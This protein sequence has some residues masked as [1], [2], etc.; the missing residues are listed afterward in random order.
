MASSLERICDLSARKRIEA[1][2]IA[3]K[4]EKHARACIEGD[5]SPGTLGPLAEFA[6]LAAGLLRDLA[7]INEGLAEAAKGY[8]GRLR[9]L[10]EAAERAGA[11][12]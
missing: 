8:G 7:D 4:L 1:A 9:L 11:L 2:A 12:A 5:R 10:H 6:D 3:S